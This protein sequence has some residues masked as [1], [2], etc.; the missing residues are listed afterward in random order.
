MKNKKLRFATIIGAMSFGLL[1]TQTQ[2]DA[3]TINCPVYSKQNVQHM[4]VQNINNIDELFKKFNIQKPTVQQAAPAPQASNNAQKAASTPKA[5][6]EAQAKP[7]AKPAAEAS[8]ASA[9]EKKVVELVNQERQKQGLQAL[10]LDTKLSDVAREKSKD[11]MNKNYFSHTSP[12][13]GSPFD[14]M[15]QFGI[16]YRT[17][18]ENIAKGQQTPE[19]VMNGWMNSDG[20]R[21]N[22][23]SP[24][25]T[26]I[27]VG[28]VE[29]GGSTYWTQM[30]IGK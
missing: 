15:K 2:A 11:M 24:N 30:F 19:E 22:I 27:G 23:L 1:A 13:Y 21:K 9:F 7:A 6:K 29:G 20:H 28:Y 16:E 25:F 8:S 17:A 14:M 12:T 10:Q 4:N 26:H 18:G 5:N 3:S